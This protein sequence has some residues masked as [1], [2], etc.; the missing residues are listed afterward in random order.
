MLRQSCGTSRTYIVPLQ[1][2][3][4]FT[5]TDSLGSSVS[6]CLGLCMGGYGPGL[7]G[8]VLKATC[9]YHFR[10][11]VSSSRRLVLHAG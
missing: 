6:V 4:D 9:L 7:N 8:R 3:L 1:K 11:F 10:V 2:D 5:P